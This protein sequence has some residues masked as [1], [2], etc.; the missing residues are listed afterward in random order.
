MTRNGVTPDGTRSVMVSVNTDSMVPKPGTP[1][2]TKDYTA[3]LIDHALCAA[4]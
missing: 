2:P 4:K 1:E 3:D